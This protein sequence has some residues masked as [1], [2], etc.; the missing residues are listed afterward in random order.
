M[1][2]INV[3]M[4]EDTGIYLVAFPPHEYIKKGFPL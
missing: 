4:K 3:I 1:D 2:S